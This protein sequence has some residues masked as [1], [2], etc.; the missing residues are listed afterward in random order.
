MFGPSLS[1]VVKQR[2]NN[3]VSMEQC[4]GI[5]ST[6]VSFGKALICIAAFA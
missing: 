6:R 4:L 2:Y 3:N 5:S 1:I